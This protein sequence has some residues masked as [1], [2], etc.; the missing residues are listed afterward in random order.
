MGLF[1]GEEE[2]VRKENLKRLEDKRVAFA[3]RLAREGFQPERML[4]TQNANGGFTAICRFKDRYWLIV[5]PGFGTDEEYIFEDYET[6]N[7][8]T[9]DVL[10]KSEGMGGIFG[11]GKKGEVG[12]EYHIAR[13]DGGEAVMSFVSSRG[14][15]LDCPLKKNP[16]LKAQR[17]RGDANVVW[18]LKPLERV[19]IPHALAVAAEYFTERPESST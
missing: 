5:S 18:E 2:R 4:F 14:G 8:R 11:F 17:R 19:D 6:L 10:V 7:W 15:W 9:Q 16:L 3:A 1:D 12:V 13:R